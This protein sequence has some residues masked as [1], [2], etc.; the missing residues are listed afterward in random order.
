MNPRAEADRAAEAERQA[1]SERRQAKLDAANAQRQADEDAAR[2]E[3]EAFAAETLAIS[4]LLD[5]H[6]L[7]AITE[8]ATR[9]LAGPLQRSALAVSHALVSWCR[10]AVAS[11]PGTSL[12]EAVDAALAAGLGP[13][14]G[15]S[16]PL[17]LPSPA[18]SR[19]LRERLT[20]LLH[21]PEPPAP[22]LEWGA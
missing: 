5:D 11:H 22:P 20:P 10:T 2:R 1:D 8:T 15:G 14:T 18:G 21:T 16:P 19:P 12:V 4:A 9:S 3:A 6:H 17:V 7:A 13:A